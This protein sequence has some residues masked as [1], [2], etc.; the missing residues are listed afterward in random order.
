MIKH[1][2]AI[3]AAILLSTGAVAQ[4]IQLKPLQ[5]GSSLNFEAQA[6]SEIPNDLAVMTFS[7]VSESKDLPTAQ[8]NLNKVMADAQK[9]LSD[10]SS[11]AKIQNYGYSAFPV[12][13]KPKEGE[14]PQIMGWKAIQR[15]Q[16]KT[17]DIE[18][19]P[20]LVQTAQ[21]AKLA[22]DNINYGLTPVTREL[23]QEKLIGM[24]IENVNKKAANVAL[25]MK[26][27]V[28]TFYI[29]KIDFN[30]GFE[31]APRTFTVGAMMASDNSPRVKMPSF[32][33]GTSNVEL[34]ARATIKILPDNAP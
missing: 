18:G 4:N 11:L 33:A 25:A 13:S 22:L 6:N 16:V 26:L 19:V 32:E 34:S 2:A 1:F 14:A 3:S 8:S 7:A 31:A 15:I 27:P 12:Y 28:E 5:T 20:A 29:E 17:E 21:N 10:F 9:I 24:V 30:Q 23:I